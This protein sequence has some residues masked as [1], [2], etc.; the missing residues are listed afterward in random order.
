MP[1]LIVCVLFGCVVLGAGLLS[2]AQETKPT[3]AASPAADPADPR[4]DELRAFRTA[5]VKTVNERDID[6]LLKHLHPNV[7]VVWQNAEISRGHQGVRDYYLKTLGGP[8][9]VL[10][11]YTID[12]PDVK[13]LTDFYGP[14]TGIS[15]GTTTSH[16]KF[17]NGNTFD[18]HGPWSATL[19]KD[20]DRW[21]IVAFHASAG[22]FDNPVLAA[23][24][25]TIYWAAGIAGAA[26]LILGAAVTAFLKRKRA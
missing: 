14:N 4:H 19:V 6:G 3:P 20:N 1:R 21:Q 13:E 7:V 10:E 9:A 8:N 15:Y 22:L 11:S 24:T 23:A 12:P 16:F 26:G 25:K 2:Q 18:L 17:K 5:V